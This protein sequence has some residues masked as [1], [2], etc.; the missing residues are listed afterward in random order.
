M[1]TKK[2]WYAKSKTDLFG[3]LEANAQ[4]LSAEEVQKRQAFFGLNT[5]PQ[6][7]QQSLLGLFFK[8]FQSPLIYLLLG[9][10]GVVSAMGEYSDGGIIALVLLINALVGAYQE[11]RAARTLAS[12]QKLVTTTATALRNGNESVISDVELVPGDILI[13]REGEKVPADCRILEQASVR[14]NESSLTGESVSQEKHADTLKTTQPLPIQEQQNMLF[15]GTLITS[16]NCTA[17]V[18]ATG[19]DTVMGSISGQV[20]HVDREIPLQKNIR[21]LANILILIVFGVSIILLLV[22]LSK[23]M[24]IRE[25]FGVVV[26]LAVSVI[27][28]GLPIAVT[29]ILASGVRRMSKRNALVKKLQSIESLGQVDVIAVDKTGTITKNEMTVTEL[30]VDGKRFT[31]T[32]QGYTEP[33]TIFFKETTVTIET[34]PA[35]QAAALTFALCGNARISKDPLSGEVV[36]AGDP[37]DAALVVVAQKMGVLR[38]KLITAHALV[39]E[40]PFDYKRKFHATVYQMGTDYFMSAVGATEAILPLCSHANK[41][42]ILLQARAASKRGLRVL[43]FAYNTRAK[44]TANEL[45]Q[46]TFG[47][48]VCMSDPIL[49]EVTETVEQLRNANI[50]TV[51]IT[52]D[53]AVT[54]RAIAEH[55]GIYTPGNT[56]LTSEEL[57][58]MSKADIAQQLATTSVFARVTPAD[59]LALVEAYGKAGNIIA[60]TGDGVND[61][62]ALL[63]ADIGLAMG[64]GG[65]EVA[66]EAAD[67][68]ILDNN[69]HTIAAAVEEGRNI[70]LTI[71]K[72]LV[73]LFSTSLGELLT[74]SAALV[75]NVPLPLI[76]V[77]II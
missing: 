26:S 39:E 71:R 25:I 34:E 35:L 20:L 69:F 64:Y 3:Y 54:A 9:A 31:V 29:L 18:V 1:E 36:I 68:V 13:L 6:A 12:L 47:G 73:Y 28:E 22:G 52:G 70:Y 23:G 66:K 62:P 65:T 51:M 67:I 59:K 43:A 58:S 24:P 41:R 56:I 33:G 16:G 10:A 50:R 61:A 15:R 63:G 21:H 40:L 60:M 57:Y 7:K 53:N 77:Q 49:P 76:A 48:L 2:L 27:P 38:D 17:I 32:G 75:L 8:Q 72:V 55:A 44:V 19:L 11:G 74:V 4:G 5:L 46:L 45:P 42:S 30:I 37:T 14:T